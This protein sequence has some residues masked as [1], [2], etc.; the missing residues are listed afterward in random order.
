M[1]KLS[2]FIT[3]LFLVSFALSAFPVSASSESLNND[4]IFKEPYIPYENNNSRSIINGSDWNNSV[5]ETAFPYRAIADLDITFS[6]GGTT[7]GTG[8][9]ISKNCMLTA[10]HCLVC[11][12]CGADAT[13]VICTFGRQSANSYWYCIVATPDDEVFYHH[14][15]YTGSQMNYDYGYIVFNLNVGNSLGWFGIAALNDTSLTSQDIT[16]SG[17]KDQIIYTANGSVTSVTS[18][19][20]SHSASTNAGQSGSPIYGSSGTYQNYAFGIHTHGTSTSVP[21]NSGW[22][23]TSSF[24]SELRGLGYVS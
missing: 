12:D 8:F 16:V 4:I 5:D 13:Q 20:I 1:K 24:I 9:L 10:G 18:T 14:P 3:I 6:C 23:I 15:S 21:Y 7:H 2:I 11:N 22:R 17:Y 19:R